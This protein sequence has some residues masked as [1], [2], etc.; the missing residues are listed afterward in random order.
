MPEIKRQ[1]LI[2]IIYTNMTN[3][4]IKDQEFYNN[5]MKEDQKKKNDNKNQ[6][7]DKSTKNITA[8]KKNEKEK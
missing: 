7:K 6:K 8:A 3:Q 2:N 1:T 5:V 4:L